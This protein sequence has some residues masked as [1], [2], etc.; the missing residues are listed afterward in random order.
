MAG[1][2]VGTS[3]NFPVGQCT[4]WADLRYHALTGSYV[5]W[6]GDAYTWLNNAHN[7]GWT[8]SSTPPTNGGKAIV[9]LQPGVQGAGCL[10]HVAV[11]E[12]VNANGTVTTSN[13]NWGCFLCGPT[14]VT[15][16]PGSGV[17]F[18]WF[19]GAP[20]TG[21]P[22]PVPGQQNTPVSPPGGGVTP[23][24]TQTGQTTPSG[25]PAI[26]NW[27]SQIQGEGLKIGL[28]A[29]ALVLLFFGAYLLFKKQ[30]DAELARVKNNT[31]RVV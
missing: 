3:D 31:M 16:R 22:T 15:F 5:P 30:I 19:P 27:V 17:S 20:G 25:V 8:V 12:S 6:G 24:V 13:Y 7:S 9:I 18:A 10:G 28:F 21:T 11:V 23:G 1:T 29:I 14:S 2:P 4:W 26:T